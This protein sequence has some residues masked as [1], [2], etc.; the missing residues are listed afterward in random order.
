MITREIGRS[1]RSAPRPCVISARAGTITRMTVSASTGK[2]P[3]LILIAGIQVGGI[4][5]DIALPIENVLL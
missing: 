2:V 5:G 4:G 3:I 1:V